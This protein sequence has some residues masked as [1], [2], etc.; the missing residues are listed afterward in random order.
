MSWQKENI[1]PEAVHA[2]LEE[3]SLGSDDSSVNQ[4]ELCDELAECLD[5]L[6]ELSECLENLLAVCMQLNMA[7]ITQKPTKST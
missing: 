7:Q 3:E 1:P 5:T 2:E 4:E 6:Q